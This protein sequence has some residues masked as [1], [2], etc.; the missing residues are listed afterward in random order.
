MWDFFALSDCN[1]NTD[2]R[3]AAIKGGEKPE[4]TKKSPFWPQRVN[5]SM[6]PRDVVKFGL[7]VGYQRKS[8]Y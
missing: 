3:N 6:C 5:N 4:R 7:K 1:H 8:A 2:E